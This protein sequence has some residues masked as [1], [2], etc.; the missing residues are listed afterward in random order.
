LSVTDRAYV[1]YEGEILL[2]G[3]A[4]ELASNEEARKLYLGERFRL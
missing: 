2:S 3:S 4:A 1:M